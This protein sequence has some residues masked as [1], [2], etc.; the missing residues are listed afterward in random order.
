MADDRER[1]EGAARDGRDAQEGGTQGRRGPGDRGPT[2]DL[3][4]EAGGGYGGGGNTSAYSAESGYGGQAGDG[5][6][7]L[8]GAYA[9]GQHGHSD[10]ASTDDRPGEHEDRSRPAGASDAEELRDSVER[11]GA[12][13]WLD[14]GTSEERKEPKER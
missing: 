7:S 1:D 12:T 6:S 11:S 4:Y 8:R 9:G 5:G 13:A 10:D 2:G 14:G 3:G